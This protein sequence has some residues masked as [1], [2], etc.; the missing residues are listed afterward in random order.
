M[1]FSL[2]HTVYNQN[3][4]YKLYAFF[5]LLF[6]YLSFSNKVFLKIK[7]LIK[8]KKKKKILVYRVNHYILCVPSVVLSH[9]NIA[10]NFHVAVNPLL[11]NGNISSRSAKILILI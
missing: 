6:K 3:I 11:P 8:K 9:S 7:S 4:G 2:W 10:E 1:F 5:F